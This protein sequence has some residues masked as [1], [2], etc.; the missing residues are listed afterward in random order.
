MTVFYRLRAWFLAIG[1]IHL[2]TATA[3]G[4][5]LER[6][7]LL[8]DTSLVVSVNVKQ[9][10]GSPAYQK[11]YQE[12][13]EQLVVARAHAE[14]APDALLCIRRPVLLQRLQRP[15]DQRAEIQHQPG[16]NSCRS[17]VPGSGARMKASP[18]RNACTD[19]ARMRA[20]SPG[21]RMPLSVTTIRS[22]GTRASTT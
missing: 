19:A 1:L 4:A 9:T 16:W 11:H 3:Y 10:V 7:Y 22:G 8:D 14:C 18:T 2:A 5:P 6:K 13:V 15:F 12:Q 20:T 21:P 17:A